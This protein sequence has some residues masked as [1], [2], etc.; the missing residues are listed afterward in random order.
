MFHSYDQIESFFHDEKIGLWHDL[1]TDVTRR[2]YDSEELSVAR[3]YGERYA[4]SYVHKI[5]N[6]W[7]YPLGSVQNIDT[8]M[9]AVGLDPYD[10][11]EDHS[12]PAGLG[13]I[14]GKR[15][16]EWMN[17]NDGLQRDMDFV[18]I[19]GLERISKYH[20]NQ[21]WYHWKPTYA[22]SK[23]FQGIRNGIVTQQTFVSPSLGIF[24][25]LYQNETDFI[26][27]KLQSAVPVLNTTEEAYVEKAEEFLKI[28]ETIGDYEKAVAELS[29]N[30]IS[31][32]VFLI[33]AYVPLLKEL[34]SSEE[35]PMMYDEFSMVTSGCAEYAATH[36]A[37]RHKRTYLAGRPKSIIRHL[38]EN[39]DSFSTKFPDAINFE[40]MIPA[41]DHPEYPSGS[42]S[43]YS[44][45]A[46]AADDWF[47][48]NFG[49]E[50]A[51]KKTGPLS[52][53][54]PASKFYWQEGPSKD[55]TLEYENLNEWIEE[56]PLSRVY[57]GVH[58]LDSGVAGVN[59][60]KEVGHSC[61][62]LLKRLKEGDMQATYTF[63][64]RESINAFN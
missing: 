49:L 10:K 18:D 45:F 25:F 40:P 43:I 42:S 44:A 34:T 1:F 61:S 59:L 19:E 7:V 2:P 16:T 53:T 21:D 33:L 14:V 13:N 6:G 46:Q 38:A 64:E 50:E 55:V 54:V 41:G 12:S 35:Y 20:V 32:S 63:S 4:E 27:Q 31:G 62:R 58:F 36:A 8:Y 47:F 3:W 39:N 26:S 23:R 56:L 11:T 17:D 48:D 30:K 15:V 28:Q 24:S 5:T 52:F 37:W 9:M 51:S 57:G 60:G 22:G 29:N